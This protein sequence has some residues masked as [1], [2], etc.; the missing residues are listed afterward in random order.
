MSTLLPRIKGHK[1]YCKLKSLQMFE[2]AQIFICKE[3]LWG[4]IQRN[5]VQYMRVNWR[6]LRQI[7]MH[8][9]QERLAERLCP[10]LALVEW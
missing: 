10:F 6:L 2:E 3:I 4:G 8:G 5:L 9:S 7:K 1:K